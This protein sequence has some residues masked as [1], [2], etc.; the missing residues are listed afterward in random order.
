MS[1]YDYVIVGGGS[2]GCV[3]AYRLSENPSASVLLLEAGGEDRADMID[4]P[5]RWLETIGSRIDWGYETADQADA[6]GRRIPWPRGKVLGGSSSMNAMVFMRGRRSDFDSW[7]MSGNTGWD[8]DAILPAFQAIESYPAGDPAYRGHAGP[9]S[10]TVAATP[11]PHSEAALEAALSVGYPFVEDLNS[12]SAIG[13]GWN[14]LSI[15]GGARCSASSAFLRPVRDRPNL[16]VITEARAQRLVLDAHRRVSAVEYLRGGRAES[17]GV[18]AEVI[19]AAGAIESPKLLLLSGIGP[20]DALAKIGIKP[21]VSLD[22][23]G[24]NLHDH[25][26]VAITF[27]SRRLIPAGRYQGSEIGLFCGSPADPTGP[28]L[29]FGIL[30]AAVPGVAQADPGRSFSFYP[31]LLKPLSRGRLTLGSPDPAGHP[32]IDPAY[33]AAPEDITGLVRAIGIS[34][35]L[36]AANGLRDWVDAEVAP[37]PD[38]DTAEDLRKYVR[39]N[40]NTWFHPVGTCRMG[41]DDLAVVDPQLRVIG[42]GNLRVAD[43]A[44]MPE[45]TSGNTNAPTLMIAWRAADLIQASA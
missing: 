37:G 15:T 43:A 33:L 2:A 3:L 20:A 28:D 13:V 12:E 36:A 10:L 22:G 16:T 9:L 25:P 18:L 41:V 1:A 31:S 30:N 7:A 26:G 42:V 29:Q 17:A 35:E 11:N 14:Q 5:T 45:V 27:T 40:V 44:V 32:V 21:L 34:R 38:V 39:G 4:D 23:V 19:L 6:D 24:E 8:Y